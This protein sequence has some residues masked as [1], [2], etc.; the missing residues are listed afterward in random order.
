MDL[1]CISLIAFVV[2]WAVGV[3]TFIP[4]LQL[5]S[6]VGNMGYIKIQVPPKGGPGGGDSPPSNGEPELG[7]FT[8]D[9]QTTKLE[10]IN[11]GTIEPGSRNFHSVFFSNLGNVDLQLGLATENW[12]PSNASDY[13]TLSWDLK[14]T[15]LPKQTGLPANFVLN[16][17]SKIVDVEPRVSEFSFDIII[18]VNTL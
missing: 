12:E 14:P 13:I 15:T 16:V 17:D 10:S 18:T 1:L 5:T 8:D 6:K 4:S 11:W 2:L 3:F 9:K 7:L